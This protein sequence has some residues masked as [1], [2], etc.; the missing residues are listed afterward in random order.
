MQGQR[1]VEPRN[2]F[3]DRER[4]VGWQSVQD[5]LQGVTPPT[6]RPAQHV[7]EPRAGQGARIGGEPEGVCGTD[8]RGG[9]DALALAGN[10]DHRGVH[11]CTSGLAVNRIG[12]NARL[13]PERDLGL[14]ALGVARNRRIRLPLPADN[15][16]GI[17]LV[18]PRQGLLR[19]QASSR[20]HCCNRG[21]AHPHAESLGDQFAHNL[22]RPQAKVEPVWPGI[23]PSDPVKHLP[24]LSRGQGPWAAGRGACCT[25]VKPVATPAHCRE[26]AIDRAAVNAVARDHVV[27]ALAHALNGSPTD[28]LQG[29]V[30]QRPSVSRQ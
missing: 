18:R 27:R 20:H 2:V 22:T 6:H 17:P 13:I 30:S 16:I 4:L 28:G 23:L 7:H 24:L 12:A 5:Q 15:H 10:L 3:R 29:A 26:P 19:R 1:A 8:G 9:A 11:A 14:G 21:Q 25:C